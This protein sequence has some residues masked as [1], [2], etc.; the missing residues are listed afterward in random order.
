MS[1]LISTKRSFLNLL[2]LA[3]VPSLFF[4]YGAVNVGWSVGFSGPVNLSSESALPMALGMYVTLVVGV[5]FL[6]EMARW[7]SGTFGVNATRQQTLALAVSSASPLLVAGASM[8][9]P[10]PWFVAI[11]GII[12]LF[13]AVYILYTGVPRIMN[14][15]EERGFIYSSSLLTVGLVFLVSAMAI[16]MVFWMNG[17]GPQY[18]S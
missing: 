16:T 17:L 18:I 15:S 9:Y 14:I 10:Q 3:A 13:G 11:T 2:F 5:L 12:A 8:V 6:S 7:M 1:N 4:Y